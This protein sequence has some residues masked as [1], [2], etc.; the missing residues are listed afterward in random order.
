[1]RFF[2]TESGKQQHELKLGG[3]VEGVRISNDGK[4]LVTTH[5][6][7]DVRVIDLPD[8]RERHLFK[9]VHKGGIWG[10][11]LSPNGQYLATAGKDAMV[12]VFDLNK[13]KLLHELKHPGETNGVTFTRDNG[14]LLTGCADATIRVFD[15]ASGKPAGELRGHASGG[16]TDLQFSSDDKLLASAGIDNTV[17][18][19]NTA[20]LSKPELLETYR[21]HDNLVFGVAISPDN[22]LLASV[23][24]ADKVLVWDLRKQEER[25]SWQR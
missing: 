16:I 24:W 11:A 21:D 6:N 14:R 13:V 22:Q 23:D 12:R 17:R 3:S 5:G 4:L 15:V 9:A 1:V 8:R 10:M 19:W 7:G 25:W 2:D 20:D 18:L